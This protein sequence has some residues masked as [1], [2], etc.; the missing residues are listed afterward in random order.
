MLNS[1]DGKA[2]V[3]ADALTRI[4]INSLTPTRHSADNYV[5]CYIPSTES[6][7]NVLEIS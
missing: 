6:P 2:N 1:K 4:Q 5:N 3:V 7:I